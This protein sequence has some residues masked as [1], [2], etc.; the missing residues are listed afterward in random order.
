[1][2]LVVLM[3]PMNTT[4]SFM[5]MYSRISQSINIIFMILTSFALIVG[6]AM[7]FIYKH[8]SDEKMRNMDPYRLEFRQH[9]LVSMLI[10]LM[11]TFC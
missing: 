10:T 4:E 2:H 9:Y 1:M 11:I 3:A 8:K 7:S 5:N 6:L